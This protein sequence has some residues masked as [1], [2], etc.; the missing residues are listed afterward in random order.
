L[1][2]GSGNLKLNGTNVGVYSTSVAV[3][4]LTTSNLAINGVYSGVYPYAREQAGS[5]DIVTAGGNVTVGAGNVLVTA[6]SWY[7]L[8]DGITTVT[9]GTGYNGAITNAVL[10]LKQA[11]ANNLIVASIPDLLITEDAINTLT[12]ESGDQISEEDF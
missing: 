3:T 8:G 12:T 11:T 1:I 2:T 5:A 7:N 6:R 9:D 10:F 4:P